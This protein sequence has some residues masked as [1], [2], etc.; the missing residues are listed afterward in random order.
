[1]TNDVPNSADLNAPAA[2]FIRENQDALNQAVGLIRQNQ[3]E[4][5]SRILFD[6]LNQF[7]GTDFKL[8]DIGKPLWQADFPDEAIPMLRHALESDSDDLETLVNLARILVHLKKWDETIPL[9]ERLRE[10]QPEKSEWHNGLAWAYFSTGNP[11]QC[12]QIIASG[13]EHANWGVDF[14]ASIQY[15]LPQIHQTSIRKARMDEAS[16][17]TGALEAL[18]GR[19]S[20][21]TWRADLVTD[22]TA[23]LRGAAVNL[24]DGA[25]PYFEVEPREPGGGPAARFPAEPQNKNRNPDSG[26]T[27]WVGAANGLDPG[28]SYRAQLKLEG[29][30]AGD[31]GAPVDFVT[32]IK[33][34]AE[35]DGM[36]AVH[37]G[38]AGAVLA[39]T[40]GGTTLAT[41][42]YFAYGEAEDRLDRRTVTKLIPP[43]RSKHVRQYA[44]D[45]LKEWQVYAV[46]CEIVGDTL[47]PESPNAYALRLISPFG[48]DRNHINGIGVIDLFLAWYGRWLAPEGSIS[49]DRAHCLDL[50]DAELEIVFRPRELDEKD[51]VI[52]CDPQCS[53]GEQKFKMKNVASNWAITGQLIDPEAPEE[54]GWSR[55]KFRFCSDPFSWTFCGNNPVE[56]TETASRYVYLPLGDVLSHHRGNFCFFFAFGDWK[57]P[58][59][60]TL[61]LQSISLQYRDWS[62]LNPD[63]GAELIG[64]PEDSL[65][66]PLFLTRGWL[67]NPHEMWFSAPYPEGPREFTWRFGAEVSPQTLKLHQN[68]LKPAKTVEISTSADGKTFTSEWRGDLPVAKPISNV[69]SALVIPLRGRPI[70]HLKVSIY[71][72]YQDDFWGLDAI[73]VFD[74]NAVPL[75]E[76]EPTSVSEDVGNLQP[77]RKLYYRLVAENAAGVTRGPVN[78]IDIP[79]TQKPAI[80]DGRCLKQTGN[81]ATLFLEIMPCGLETEISVRATG[82]GGKSW[83]GPPISVGCNPSVRHV[84][85]VVEG[86]GRKGR[87]KAE[88]TAIN[89]AGE[90]EPF[91]LEW[92]GNGRQ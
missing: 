83:Q 10:R 77:G 56:Q 60:G 22:S 30:E 49:K 89:G 9:L 59:E 52:I 82:P 8:L 29:V 12:R 4:E 75:P 35:I 39:G 76:L 70:S 41:E 27:V 84:C 91:I 11:E 88:I 21:R 64:F 62:V 78:V 24:A 72:G 2:K 68:T 32:G 33:A 51:F 20:A 63:A 26:V 34:A 5:G 43:G 40:L 31:I 3:L 17:L 81:R 38:N 85:Y 71:S 86:G 57:N 1:M 14:Q 80:T 16:A 19:S 55:L 73:E 65:S 44:V 15:S 42:Y 87:H 28:Q 36:T 13:L 25:A 7:F 67:D 54:G 53:T 6:R 74:G 61:D 46:E 47:D 79:A 48:K 69:P 58:P 23:R 66:D 90:S 18:Y 50:R 45:A 92:E 37:A